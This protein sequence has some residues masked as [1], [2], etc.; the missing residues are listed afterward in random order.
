[1]G[2][3]PFS[4]SSFPSSSMNK[5]TSPISSL[6]RLLASAGIVTWPFVLSFAAPKVFRNSDNPKVREVKEYLNILLPTFLTRG[7]K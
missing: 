6:K 1:M 2:S 7:E 5:R 4:I 3:Y